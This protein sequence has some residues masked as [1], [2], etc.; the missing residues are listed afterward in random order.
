MLTAA[1]GTGHSLKRLSQ[2]R[3]AAASLEVARFERGG[4]VGSVA[5]DVSRSLWS[6]LCRVVR[7]NS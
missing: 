3:A 5:S 6:D 7:A 4:G 1:L 2:S